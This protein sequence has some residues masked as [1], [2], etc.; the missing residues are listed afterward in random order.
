MPTDAN[1]TVASITERPANGEDTDQ[2]PD[3]A[4]VLQVGSSVTDEPEVAFN[5]G[6]LSVELVAGASYSLNLGS[7]DFNPI[8]HFNQMFTVAEPAA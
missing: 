3:T 7:V 6:M 2:T 8:L 5:Q 4:G 1:D